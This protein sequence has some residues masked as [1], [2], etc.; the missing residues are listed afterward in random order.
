MIVLALALSTLQAINP[1]SSQLSR[2]E[3]VRRLAQV[4]LRSFP[5]EVEAI[6]GKPD[7]I[8]RPTAKPV[9]ESDVVRWKY[10]SSGPGT[11]ATLG[12][13]DFQYGKVSNVVGR[14]NGEVPKITIDERT[15]RRCMQQL[16]DITN[17]NKDE[18]K[19]D[20]LQLIRGT[21]LLI[22]MGQQKATDALSEYDRAYSMSPFAWYRWAVRLAYELP[23][24]GFMPSFTPTKDG[25]EA[26]QFPRWPVLTLQDTPLLLPY[27][28]V[29][30]YRDSMSAQMKWLNENTIM[31]SKPIIPAADPFAIADQILNESSWPITTN[32]RGF[33]PLPNRLAVKR[34]F[35]AQL[36]RL[37]RNAC[38]FKE[39]DEY[40]D[41]FKDS[42]LE[43]FHQDFLKEKPRWDAEKQ[44]YVKG[45]GTFFADPIQLT[46]PAH[47][48]IYRAQNRI[49]CEVELQEYRDSSMPECRWF[50]CNISA[51]IPGNTH[52]QP[53]ALRLASA[54]SGDQI[55]DFG[56]TALAQRNDYSV[57][58]ING[59]GEERNSAKD[60]F[61]SGGSLGLRVPYDGA[62]LVQVRSKA[63]VLRSRLVRL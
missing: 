32:S 54:S 9:F 15:L 1:A 57:F 47:R 31:R 49:L 22:S 6:L 11:F 48:F 63:R 21:N 5:R 35:T 26:K 13:V 51:R 20:L 38:T 25:A 16:D 33:N 52:V 39:M 34:E 56:I 29:S 50:K 8:E 36:L 10:G 44:T 7:D 40:G 58:D 62:V 2:A 43:R 53:L 14:P 42:D 4:E 28:V 27:L 61:L 12:E 55:C 46:Y 19:T 41:S 3:F 45:D 18:V 23:S 30:G 37:V 17:L 24:T 60:N 59:V